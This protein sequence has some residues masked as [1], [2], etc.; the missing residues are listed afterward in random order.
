MDYESQ[1]RVSTNVPS[2]R[3]FNRGFANVAASVTETIHCSFINQVQSML[4]TMKP[5]EASNL[6]INLSSDIQFSC[7]VYAVA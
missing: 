4:Q 5:E 1:V 2:F 3:F 6:R 7:G